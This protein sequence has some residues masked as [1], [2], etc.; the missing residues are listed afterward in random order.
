MRALV[1]AFGWAVATLSA[2]AAFAEE[3][4][5][6]LAVDGMS[7]AACPYMVEEALSAVPGVSW[8]DVSYADKTA[9]VTFEDTQ[10]AV[11]DLI[12]ATMQIGFPASPKS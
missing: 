10:A 7:C 8:V 4:T 3:E 5:I 11:A 1:G 12:A 9:T 6:T 2:S